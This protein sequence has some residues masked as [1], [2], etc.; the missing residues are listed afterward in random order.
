MTT[1]TNI[2]ICGEAGQGLATLG[3][4]LTRCLV[5]AGQEI[6]VTQDYQSRI[7]GGLNSFAVRA[8][9]G[10]IT[11]PAET[12]D[13][14]IALSEEA[15]RVQT[16]FL[17]EKGLIILDRKNLA[18]DNF[19]LLSQRIMAIS[20]SDFGKSQQENT[21]ALGLAVA[22]LGL[23]RDIT[24]K[25]VQDVFK[26][27][28]T[29]VL[30]ANLAAFKSAY[31]RGEEKAGD[32]LYLE[33]PEDFPF[34]IAMNGNEAIALGAVSAGMKFFSF[35]PMTP[36]TSIALTL[37]GIAEKMGL[38]LEQAEDEIAA[39]NMAVGASFAGAPAMCATS[40]GGFALMGEGVSLAAMTETPLTIVI[41]QRP[42]P[43]T[44][45]PTRSAQADLNMVINAGHGEFA[46]AVYAP[47]T[48]EECFYLTRS[49]IFLAEESQGPVFVL[50]DQFLA[51][52]IRAVLPFEV[53]ELASVRPG[54]EEE[55]A[56][57]PYHR[58]ALTAN[59]VSPRLIPG[60]TE[61]LVVADSDE[62]TTDG[63]LT[64]DL[65]AAKEMMDKRLKKQDLLISEIIPPE[66][67][68]PENPDLLLVCW[69][70]TKGAG[71]EAINILAEEERKK[72]G[73]LHFSQVWPLNP[74][75]FIKRLESAGEVVALEGNAGGQL[76]KLIHSASGF[77]IGP[78]ISRY[79]GL[80]FTPEY[81]LRA[82]DG[83]SAP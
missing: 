10:P 69:G 28:R 9:R 65:S 19:G 70:S 49:A 21:G 23:N 80:P 56:E 76:K 64:E 57:K 60:L 35:Y 53:K 68:G 32:N 58:Y 5:R 82:L 15:A 22:V 25:V 74:D 36:S 20:F 63:H 24:E 42:G 79:D 75:H 48:V 39:V 78:L 33:T 40:G 44:G 51:D 50:T 11:A 55:F 72:A 61:N 4:L 14:I 62:H 29:D 81:I 34:R 18:K 66:Y 2:L 13:L 73:L 47:G 59:G 31:V 8:G 52:S 43:A 1:G 27:S 67:W 77:D 12:F 26:K 6:V 54:C 71:L 83:R 30:E 37:A 16:P 46:R 45:L 38:V 3:S 17:S 41:S 7:R